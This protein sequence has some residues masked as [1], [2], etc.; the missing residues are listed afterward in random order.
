MLYLF[1]FKKW[2]ILL[3]PKGC[4]KLQIMLNPI[5]SANPIRSALHIHGCRIYRYVEPVVLC[6]CTVW[7]IRTLSIHEF[8]YPLRGSGINP[9]WIPREYILCFFPMLT[10]RQ[11]IQHEYAGHRDDSGPGRM[12]QKVWDFITLLT[13]NSI[14]FKTFCLFQECSI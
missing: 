12:E 9:L 7:Y 13:Q 4:Q 14:Q 11:H 5:E 3:E 10:N 6:H 1:H 8:W 2:K